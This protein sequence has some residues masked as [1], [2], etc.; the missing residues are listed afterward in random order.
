[1]HL[2]TWVVMATGLQMGA[3]SRVRGAAYGSPQLLLNAFTG[4]DVFNV[5]DLQFAAVAGRHQC[6]QRAT[7]L[8]RRSSCLLQG[9]SGGWCL[10]P[11]PLE[12]GPHPAEAQH[13]HIRCMHKRHGAKHACMLPRRGVT[14]CRNPGFHPALEVVSSSH[15]V[16]PASAAR[17]G[18]P[19]CRSHPAPPSRARLPAHIAH[20]S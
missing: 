3:S 6:L 4:S 20:R 9:T 13:L 10:G 8:L 17:M 2:G 18:G 12:P 7:N 14:H 15:C 1:M 16:V 11:T 5:T 19:R